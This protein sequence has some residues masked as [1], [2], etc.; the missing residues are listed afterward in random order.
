[1][2]YDDWKDTVTTDH[3]NRLQNAL[4]SWTHKYHNSKSNS[5][6]LLRRVDNESDLPKTKEQVEALFYPML[7]DSQRIVPVWKICQASG[8]NNA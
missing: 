3:T 5:D 4:G 7:R 6:R 1:M 8:M 2:K